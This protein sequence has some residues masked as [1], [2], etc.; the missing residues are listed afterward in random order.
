MRK[1]PERWRRGAV[2]QLAAAA[3]GIYRIEVEIASG[4]TAGDAVH[5]TVSVPGQASPP[6]NIPVR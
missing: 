6:V 3:V 2:S 1:T 4:I 5:L